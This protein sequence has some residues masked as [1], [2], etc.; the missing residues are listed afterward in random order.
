MVKIILAI[1]VMACVI[2][3]DCLIQGNNYN[4]EE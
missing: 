1:I 4:K 3:F 2:A